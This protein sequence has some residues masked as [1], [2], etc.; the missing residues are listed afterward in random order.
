MVYNELIFENSLKLYTVQ[1]TPTKPS[2]DGPKSPLGKPP[3]QIEGQARDPKGNTITTPT[4]N[5]K[6][7]T[8]KKERKK[9]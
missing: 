7:T 4:T 1:D 5:K 9:D 8:P 3:T 6:K 2:N